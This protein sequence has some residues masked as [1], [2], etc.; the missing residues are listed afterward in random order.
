M[1]LRQASECVPCARLGGAART[2]RPGVFLVVFIPVAVG[3]LACGRFRVKVLITCVSLR[4]RLRS[5]PKG[6][7]G[8]RREENGVRACGRELPNRVCLL[9]AGQQCSSPVP[10]PFERWKHSVALRKGRGRG[11][12]DGQ[13]DRETGREKQ[14]PDLLQPRPLPVVLACWNPERTEENIY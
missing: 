7:E 9:E 3:S 8:G 6:D 1:R 4:K 11:R 2:C 14:F 12:T 10:C 5:E 13:T